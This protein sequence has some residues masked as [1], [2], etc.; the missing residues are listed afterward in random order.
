MLYPI[1]KQLE[2]V[3]F[4]KKVDGSPPEISHRSANPSAAGVVHVGF[5]GAERWESQVTCDV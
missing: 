4:Q 1:A 2:D 3:H 5:P